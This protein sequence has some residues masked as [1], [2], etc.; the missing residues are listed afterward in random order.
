ML[1]FALAFFLGAACHQAVAQDCPAVFATNRINS[2]VMVEA[3]AHGIHSITVKDI[4]YYFD[5]SFPEINSIPTGLTLKPYLQ[6]SLISILELMRFLKDLS[7]V[8]CFRQ[9]SK[10]CEKSKFR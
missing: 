10:G 4:R 2:T 8:L 5:S 7:W 3:I 9:I 6:Y 1:V